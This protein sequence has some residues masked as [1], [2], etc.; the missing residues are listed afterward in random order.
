MTIT[1]LKIMVSHMKC[2]TLSITVFFLEQFVMTQGFEQINK[3]QFDAFL[4][5]NKIN[6]VTYFLILA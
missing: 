5:G 1:T 3:Y 4:L 6:A 2:I